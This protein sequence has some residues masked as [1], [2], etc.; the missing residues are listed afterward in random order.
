MRLLLPLLLLL[1][2]TRL[3]AAADLGILRVWPGYRS[4]ESFD[5][6]SEYFNGQENTG[7][8]TFL[9]TQPADRAGYYFFVRTK[10]RAA[11]VEAASVVVS[12]ITPD[13]PH[14]KV[15]ANFPATALPKGGHVFQIGL[16]G[17]DWPDA[18]LQPVAWQLRFLAA[19]GTELLRH[20]SFLWSQPPAK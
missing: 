18:Q 19:D 13:S 6:I 17:A 16:T 7:G 2:A 10:N 1:T 3:F 8:Q 9:R 20:Q 12:V 5:R 4:A 11:P 14:P 15:F